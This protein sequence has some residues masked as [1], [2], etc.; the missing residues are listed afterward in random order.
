MPTAFSCSPHIPGSTPVVTSLNVKDG[1][2]MGPPAQEQSLWATLELRFPLKWWLCLPDSMLGL[3]YLYL[4]SLESHR[5]SLPGKP[6][7][8]TAQWLL[9]IK[10]QESL[11]T[12]HPGE[13]PG[14][15]RNWTPT[16]I[17]PVISSLLPGSITPV[18]LRLS[19]KAGGPRP[20]LQGKSW[21]AKS[22]TEGLLSPRARRFM[23]L[24]CI[25]T[26][27]HFLIWDWGLR[28]TSTPRTQHPFSIESVRDVGES[29]PT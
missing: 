13:D 23:I 17:Q 22:W 8:N 27:D 12:T 6:H 19:S 9:S 1:V 20:Y 15:S 29:T 7:V 26:T 16:Y 28:S 2:G 11:S 14:C 10:G 24:T 3:I 25:T 18:A 4:Y 5:N 21:T